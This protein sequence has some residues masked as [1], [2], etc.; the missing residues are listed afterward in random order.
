MAA[1]RQ[2]QGGMSIKT[3]I[4]RLH[5]GLTEFIKVYREYRAAHSPLYAAKTA[6]GIAFRGLPF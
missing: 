3:F 5:H 4:K 1:I 2:G 6:Y